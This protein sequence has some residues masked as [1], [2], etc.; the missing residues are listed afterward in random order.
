[1]KS[2]SFTLDRGFPGGNSVSLT[3]PN[4]HER[5]MAGSVVG[6]ATRAPPQHSVCAD[7]TRAHYGRSSH[8]YVRFSRNPMLGLTRFQLPRLQVIVSI[9]LRYFPDPCHPYQREQ[10]A[11]RLPSHLEVARFGRQSVD[12]C[13]PEID[14]RL[15]QIMVIQGGW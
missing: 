3:S 11:R 1:M 4:G 8:Q 2:L 7:K 12:P 9:P 15:P 13:R 10:R 5:T 14:K 6:K